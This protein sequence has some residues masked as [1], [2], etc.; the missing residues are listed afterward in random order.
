MLLVE[1]NE[2]VREFAR[3]LLVDLGFQV[4]GAASAAE[5]LE[6]LAERPFDLLFTDIVMPGQTGID[7]ARTVRESYPD[8]PVL[9]TTGYSDELAQGKAREFEILAKPYS[10]GSLASALAA[11][12]EGGSVPAA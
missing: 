3:G 2:Q 5:A 6:N 9:L 8:L 10:A 4:V 1:D 12:A 7:L 11:L